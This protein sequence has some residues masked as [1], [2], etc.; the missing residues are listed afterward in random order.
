MESSVRLGGGIRH[1]R[2]QWTLGRRRNGYFRART[3]DQSLHLLPEFIQRLLQNSDLLLLRFDDP[4]QFFR[5]G[6]LTPDRPFF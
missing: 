1:F 2:G 5:I 3:I 4:E 6:D